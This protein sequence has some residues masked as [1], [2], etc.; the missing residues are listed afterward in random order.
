MSQTVRVLIGGKEYPL[1]GDDNQTI[2][3]VASLVNEQLEE[4]GKKH[5]GKPDSVLTVLAALNIA[6][7]NCKLQQ[8]IEVNQNY[9]LSELDKMNDFLNTSIKSLK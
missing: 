5:P 1:K 2:Q 4:A 9:L 3:K 8:Q 6:E 7:S